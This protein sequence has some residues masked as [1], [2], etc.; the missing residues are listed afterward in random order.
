MN[1]HIQCCMKS[2]IHRIYPC[3]ILK[4]S[5]K[6]SKSNKYDGAGGGRRIGKW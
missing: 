2:N 5:N 1:N 6:I 3:H 4:I